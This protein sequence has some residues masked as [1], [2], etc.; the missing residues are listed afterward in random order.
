M[1]TVK[2]MDNNTMQFIQETSDHPLGKRLD[3]PL[4]EEGTTV[5]DNNAKSDEAW[6]V[7]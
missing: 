2:D 4:P 1:E 6:I 5:V 7:L 3:T